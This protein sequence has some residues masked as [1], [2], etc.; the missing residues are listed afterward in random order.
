LTTEHAIH[1]SDLVVGE[2]IEI[3]DSP[4]TVVASI[5][6]VKEVELEPQVEE[7]AAPEVIGEEP[8][9]ETEGGEE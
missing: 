9:E 6:V 4:E 8:A 1:V 2:G 7:G 3:H 5:V